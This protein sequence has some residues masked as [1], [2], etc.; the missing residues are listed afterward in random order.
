MTRTPILRVENLT[1]HFGAVQA[2]NN[3]SF[4]VHDHEVVALVGDNA[5][6][7]ST[8]AQMVAGALTPTAGRIFVGGHPVTI[9]SPREAFDLGI[10]TVYQQ[11]ALC[12]N[13]D[14]TSNIFLGRELTSQAGLLDTKE[15][16]RLAREYLDQLGGRIPDVHAPLAALSG[17]QRQGVAIARTL[18]AEPSLFVMDEPTASL[19]V[20]Q[21]ADVL[22]Y[23]EGLREM[24]KGVILISHNLTDVRA[25]ADRIIVLRHGRINGEFFAQ[26]ASY[27]QVIAAITGLT[28]GH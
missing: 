15:M 17:G 18:V 19:S 12:E 9:A 6:G 24:G 8:V 27:E 5:A 22:N 26:D 14:V 21:T 7:K 2:A 13:L 11:L 16:D 1:K 10:A 20:S 28:H 25:I 23:I 3:V 4:S